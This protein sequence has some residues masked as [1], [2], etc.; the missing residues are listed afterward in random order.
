[1]ASNKGEVV[2]MIDKNWRPTDPPW[3]NPYPLYDESSSLSRIHRAYEAGAS[4]I[5]PE[6]EAKVLRKVGEWFEGHPA[7]WERATAIQKLL[8]DEMP[9]EVRHG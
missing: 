7:A 3:K 2:E 5:I 6:V 9:E 4:A 8:R 1:M